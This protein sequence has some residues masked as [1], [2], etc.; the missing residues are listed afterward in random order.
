MS[1][2]ESDLPQ[3]DEPTPAKRPRR[4]MLWFAGGTGLL[5]LVVTLTLLI[6]ANSSG[7]EDLIRRRIV[8]ELEAMTGGRIEI[9]SLHWRLFDLEADLGGVVIHG[10][11]AQNE[12]P[13]ARVDDLHVGISVLNIFSPSIRLR[14]LELTRLAVHLIVYPDGTTNQPQPRRG[15]ASSGRKGLDTFFKLR[16]GH[17]A[18]EEGSLDFESRS[19]DFDF[20]HR[21]LRLDFAANDVSTILSYLP[22]S[23]RNPEG[24]R[25]EAGVHDLP[26]ESRQTLAPRRIVGRP[27]TFSSVPTSPTMQLIF[28]RS[29]S[30][31]AAR[32]ARTNLDSL[33][34]AERLHPPPLAGNGPGRWIGHLVAESHPGL[35]QCA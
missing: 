29:A 14:H 24:Y 30:R 26:F 15:M 11:E 19:T 35:S 6:W 27:V 22:A 16:A 33:G 31:Q 5:L 12:A 2:F 4:R 20:Q 32:G 3:D 21:H 10:R 34:L 8:A 28:A 23:G 7:C 13:Y 9:A 25:I 17:I 1:D 18:V